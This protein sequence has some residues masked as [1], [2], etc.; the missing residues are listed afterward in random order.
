MRETSFIKQNQDKWREFESV[1]AGQYHDPDKLND[2]FVQITDDLSYSR[3]FYP[4]RSVRVYLN[5]LAQRIFFTIYKSRRAPLRRIGQFWLDELPQLVYESRRAFLLSL[6]VFWIA[7]GIGLLSSAMDADFVK[8]ILGESYVEMTNTNIESGDPMAVYKQRGQFGMSVG[9]TANNLWVAFLTFVMGVFYA[10]GSIAIMIQNG[11]M[12][13]A[14]QYFFIEKGLFWESFLTI[15]IHG[16]LE[17]SAIIIAGAAGIVMGEGLAFPG[18]Y[19]RAQAFQRSARRGVKIMIGIAPII[20]LAGFIEGYLTRHTETPDLVRG[21]FIGVCLL[22]VLVYF[23]WYP[24]IKAR[25]DA[26]QAPQDAKIP[27]DQRQQIDFTVVKSSGEIFGDIFNFYTRHFGKVALLSLAGA[28]L[29]TAA[30]WILSGY[31]LAEQVLF[32]AYLFG[33]LEALPQFFDG[34]ASPWLSWLQPFVLG[35]LLTGVFVWLHREY[36]PQV[37]YPLRRLLLVFAKNTTALGTLILLLATVKSYGFY[38]VLAYLPIVLLWCFIMQIEGRSL[39][40]ALG[41]LLLLLQSNLSRLAGLL[42][43]LV[44]VGALFFLINDTMLMGFYLNLVSWVISL[45][46]AGMQQLSAVLL[47]FTTLFVLQMVL[48]LFI[49]GFGLLYYTLREIAE[50]TYL[51]ARIRDIGLAKRIKGLEQEG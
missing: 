24:Y 28:I 49:I 48:V 32:P 15:W 41:R 50:A 39:P 3:T 45:D 12:V 33:T 27:P 25:Y 36:D 22:F 1:L 13:G 21:L 51:R 46:E 35:A 20:I 16:T 34:T 6:L 2:L 43:V 37:R 4:N 5:G 26:D 38:L 29:L 7:F 30:A 9:I 8:I 23:V 47:T 14:F 40:G 18:T 44:L 31:K 10:V 17:I 11:I 42:L 19:T